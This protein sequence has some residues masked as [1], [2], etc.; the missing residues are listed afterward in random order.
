MIV[1]TVFCRH[2]RRRHFVATSS[3]GPIRVNTHPRAEEVLLREQQVGEKEAGHG[4]IQ[5]PPPG[6]RPAAYVRQAGSHTRQGTPP[7]AVCPNL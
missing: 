5:R 2:R 1:S 6:P 3:A 7:R 4:P